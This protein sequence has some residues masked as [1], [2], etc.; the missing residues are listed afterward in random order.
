MCGLLSGRDQSR[1]AVCSFKSAPQGFA[2]H[3]LVSVMVDLGAHCLRL[4]TISDVGGV[5]WEWGSPFLVSL[6]TSRCY[7]MGLMCHWPKC[8]CFFVVVNNPIRDISFRTGHTG[9]VMRS[10]IFACRLCHQSTK[11]QTCLG[12]SSDLPL[13]TSQPNS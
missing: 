9:P 12:S 7:C 5:I 6:V 11:L 2:Q 13:F 1:L 10:L 3:V 8:T 4:A